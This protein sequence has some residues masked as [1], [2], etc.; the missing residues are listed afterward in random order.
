MVM[1]LFAFGFIAYNI[2]AFLFNL[3]SSIADLKRNVI[4]TVYSFI[5]NAVSTLYGWLKLDA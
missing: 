2:I 3:N 1:G 4:Y 5:R